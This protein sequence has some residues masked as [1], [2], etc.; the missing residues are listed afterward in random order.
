MKYIIIS[1]FLLGA[2]GLRAQDFSF[3][4]VKES[5]F[6]VQS[7]LLDS[8]ANG[9]VLN[10][11]GYAN[12]EL[13]PI[14]DKGFEIEYY[15]HVLIK[16]LNKEGYDEANFTVPLYV[17]NSNKETLV[18]TK[19]FTYNMEAGKVQ[20]VELGKENVLTEKTTKTQH[21]VKI[22]F[23][24]VKEGSIVEL[25]Y[26][27]KSPFLFSLNAW[28]FQTTIPKLRSEFV[29]RIPE[30]CTYRINL[31]GGMPLSN[32]KA[33]NY[34]TQLSTSVGEV[35]GE[36]ISYLMTDVPAFVAEDYMTASKNFRSILTFELARY[37]IPFGPNETFS[38][39]W[40]DVHRSLVDDENFGGQLKR[41]GALK[42]FID[43]LLV[44]NANDFDKA[45]LIYDYIRKQ[46]KWNERHGLFASV[47]IKKA[48]ETRTGNSADI[49]L[50]LV[51]ALNYA[52]IPAEPI[53]LSTR[54]NGYP[55]MYSAGMSEFNH[56]IARTNIDG[57]SFYLDASSRYEPFGNLPFQ[58]INYQGRN[59]PLDGQ[60]D[61]VP[62]Q[63][64]LVSSLTVYFD[65]K[66]DAEGTLKGKL[67]LNRGGYTATSKRSAMDAVTSIEEYFEDY[68]EKL[69]HMNI[70]EAEVENREN[71]EMLLKESMDVEITN[72]ATVDNK[73]LH[74]NPIVYGK[75]EKNPFNLAT[76]SYP[77]DIGAK[78]QENMTFIIE[79]PEG[80]TIT[81][82]SLAA[83]MNM[84]LPNR[85]A[86]FVYSLAQEGNILTVQLLTQINKPLFLPEEYFDLKEFFSRII[87]GQKNSCVLKQKG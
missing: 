74:F 72:F 2:C 17:N 18:E 57:Q 52:G 42:E 26:K 30:I 10:E 23:P 68:Q 54:D 35:M 12:I 38:L 21:F 70:T 15:Y 75:T 79:V 5:D 67:T 47:G 48:L 62:L 61:W 11:Y 86:R 49:N 76:R 4:K 56:V 8:S 40:N 22:A 66:L 58:C 36:K 27:T 53:I 29:T 71:C 41:K 7:P 25:R 43:P 1:L 50:A 63:A 34:N 19:G 80:F 3:G 6:H 44:N 51:S 82:E 64:N 45:K 65:G 16:I 20:K 13:S 46:V 31:K 78:T 37:A 83:K 55:G 84:A 24:Q 9:I 32:R 59:I 85:D 69:T 81:E 87:Q 60:S 77:V 73:E 39:T 14:G 33:E 28:T